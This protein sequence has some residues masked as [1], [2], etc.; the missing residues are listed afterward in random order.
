M[1]ADFEALIRSLNPDGEPWG[2]LLEHLSW[3]VNHRLTGE[4]AKDGRASVEKLFASLL[5]KA[6]EAKIIFYVKNVPYY[7]REPNSDEHDYDQNSRRAAELGKECVDHWSVFERVVGPLSEG[8]TRQSFSFGRSFLEATDKPFDAI[9]LASEAL[10]AAHRPNQSLLGG[11]IT[12]LFVRDR[13][14]L[15]PL[16]V[17]ISKIP[18]LRKFLPYFS[19]LNLT[20]EGLSL[21]VD[22]IESGDL[23]P[24]EASI[25]GT[26]GVLQLMPV[27]H[28]KRLMNG[29]IARGEK[30][31]WVAVDLL[32]MYLHS[33]KTKLLAV[34]EEVDR[35]IRAAPFSVGKSRDAMASHHYETLVKVLLGDTKY[36]LELAQFLAANS[37]AIV[38]P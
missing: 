5:P 23:A 36:G 19:A 16:L 13:E 32:S 38:T 12:A 15:Y 7:F 9:R 35:A 33:D 26:R 24:E 27:P 28:I 2:Q 17:R 8:E 4:E 21:V 20:P 22:L 6:L 11:M 34:R 29:L 10:E 30:G 25:F 31:A 1:F 14:A 3:Q 37:R 18:S